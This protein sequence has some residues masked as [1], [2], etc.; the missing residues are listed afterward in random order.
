[1]GAILG[2]GAGTS[3]IRVSGLGFLG[4]EEVGE[5]R[6]ATVFSS[7]AFAIIRDFCEIHRRNCEESN[8]ELKCLTAASFETLFVS[9]HLMICDFS[10]AD[11]CFRL[12]TFDDMAR[13]DDGAGCC[14]LL[15]VTCMSLILLIAE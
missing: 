3:T 13:G 10:Q 6:F 12:C 7:D 9:Y 11:K 1:M 14:E 5:L 4:L 8:R 15:V 2:R